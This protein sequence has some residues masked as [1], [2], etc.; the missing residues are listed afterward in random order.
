M[1]AYYMPYGSHASV[2]S[3]P[4][5]ARGER[6]GAPCPVLHPVPVVVAHTHGARRRTYR[7]AR[8]RSSSSSSP[9]VG[10]VLLFV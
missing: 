3:T 1:G 10:R 7:Q 2:A 6:P 4:R 5:N 8:V 9:V